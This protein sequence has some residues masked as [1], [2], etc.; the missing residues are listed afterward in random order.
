[1]DE[2]RSWLLTSARIP[3][4]RIDAL[5]T[6]LA[7]QWVED[8]EALRNSLDVLEEHLPAAAYGAIAKAMRAE[9][10]A[11]RRGRR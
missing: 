7:S 4:A 3:S 2:L 9:A 1:M 6:A 8:L 5:M 11:E 10:R